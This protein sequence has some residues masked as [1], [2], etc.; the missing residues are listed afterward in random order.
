MQYGFKI[1]PT[2]RKSFSS[3]VQPATTVTAKTIGITKRN[4]VNPSSASLA[5]NFHYGLTSIV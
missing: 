2:L 5:S 4:I 1:V 3:D